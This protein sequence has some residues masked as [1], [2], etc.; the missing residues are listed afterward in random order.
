MNVLTERQREIIDVAIEIIATRGIQNL[1]IKNISMKI[2]FSEPAVYRHFKSKTEIL[3]SILSMFEDRI[4]E[5]IA[6]LNSDKSSSLGKLNLICTN[7]FNTFSD[8]PVMASVIF[9]EEIFQ[10]EK[11]LAE[12]IYSIMNINFEF[13]KTIIEKG[14]E[15][16]EIRS[17]IEVEQ[18]TM[19]IMGS[20]RLIIKRWTLSNY[21]FDL[22]S[23]GKKLWESL[24]KILSK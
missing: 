6:R 7:H 9:S 4:Q 21:S 15:S 16:K 24:N 10:D 14:V 8:N 17:D 22:K 11:K 3:L 2:G 13:M 12:K 19:I 23:D 20:L 5:F 18:L 1:T